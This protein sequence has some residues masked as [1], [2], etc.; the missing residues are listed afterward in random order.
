MSRHTV[1]YNGE[2]YDSSWEVALAQRLDELEIHFVKP[3][4]ALFYR[5]EKGDVRQYYPD[6]Y[7]VNEMVYIEVKN[8][9]LFEK[10][11]KV[12]TLRTDRTDIIWLTSKEACQNFSISE[13]ENFS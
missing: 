12:Q 13:I 8:L 4:S 5:D 11:P 2:K 9:F 1:E 7:L 10:D 3:K 6:F